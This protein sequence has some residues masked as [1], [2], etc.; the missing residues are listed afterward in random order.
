LTG[1]WH[2]AKLIITSDEKKK[3]KNTMIGWLGLAGW[4]NLGVL[5]LGGKSFK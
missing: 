5:P 3:E 2:L 4:S 1:F